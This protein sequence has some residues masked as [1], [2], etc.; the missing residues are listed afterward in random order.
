LWKT[1]SFGALD[2]D[3]G[4][5]FGPYYYRL[6]YNNTST[7]YWNQMSPL[8]IS[9][10]SNPLSEPKSEDQKYASGARA[11]MTDYHI[12]LNFFSPTS[13][14]SRQLRWLLV[15]CGVIWSSLRGTQHTWQVEVRLTSRLVLPAL[16][17]SKGSA[18]GVV[19]TVA[20]SLTVFPL[21]QKQE[22]TSHQ[23]MARDSA[24]FRPSMSCQL[25]G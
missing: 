11:P 10:A 3:L 24:S 14:S 17:T 18:L 25:A 5:T 22:A 23:H 1:T 2:L 12:D 20:E 6:P 13:T 9:D 8:N 4:P 21:V 16:S 7:R 19:Q 15:G